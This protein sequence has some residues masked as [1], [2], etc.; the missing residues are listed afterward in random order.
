[1]SKQDYNTVRGLKLH[2][3]QNNPRNQALVREYATHYCTGFMQKALLKL[4]L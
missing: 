2:E 3:I 4:A 1:M